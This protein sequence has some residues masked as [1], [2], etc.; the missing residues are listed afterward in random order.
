NEVTDM[1]LQ[2]GA[3]YSI[4]V[5]FVPKEEKIYIDTV[6]LK[7]LT[8]N[9][10]I[11][12]QLKGEG[13]KNIDIPDTV[14]ATIAV[15]SIQAKV[16]ENV[17]VCLSIQQSENFT[18]R[19]PRKFRAQI[20]CNSTV[21]FLNHPGLLCESPQEDICRI[22]IE[23]ERGVSDT[24]AVINA[25][26]TLGTAETSPIKLISFAWT[27]T[28]TNVKETRTQDGSIAIVNVCK[29]GSTRLFIPTGESQKLISNPNPVKDNF[30]IEYGL[31]ESTRASLDLIDIEGRVVVHFF[32][33]ILH[34]AGTYVHYADA[35][36][37]G[38]GK[39]I[40]RLKTESTTMIRHIE[41]L[42]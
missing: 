21:L 9:R 4:L 30:K 16:G 22:F 20:E 11:S 40:L 26:A 3:S 37:F 33:N 10:E 39:Y 2:S 34:A 36:K 29:E 5:D 41:I 1:M 7:N 17:T 6:L 8:D 27:D 24:L 23:G 32:D 12:I 28:T 14:R 35:R 19:T 38:A 25:I 31:A 13:I 42:Q 18:E 15:N